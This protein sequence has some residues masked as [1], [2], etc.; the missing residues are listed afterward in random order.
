MIAPDEAI[1]ALR[2][3]ADDL[4]ALP[5]ERAAIRLRPLVDMV[6]LGQEPFLNLMAIAAIA[7]AAAMYQRA[8]PDTIPVYRLPLERH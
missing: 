5:P 7:L 6:Q 8:Q 4:A 3:Y 1:A 2:R